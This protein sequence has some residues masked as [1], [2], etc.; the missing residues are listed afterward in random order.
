M[1]FSKPL[2]N[3]L[4]VGHLYR[5]W[6]LNEY[7]G[8]DHYNQSLVFS[9]ATKML[10]PA[11][12][13]HPWTAKHTHAILAYFSGLS[14]TEYRTRHTLLALTKHWRS[15]SDQTPVKETKVPVYSFAN[16][17][18]ESTSASY[19]FKFC[20]YCREQDL[21]AYGMSYW[22]REHHLPGVDICPIHEVAL[23]QVSWR[24]A[25]T[26]PNPATLEGEQLDEALMQANM[27]PILS[28][29]RALVLRA[30]NEATHIQYGNAHKHLLERLVKLGLYKKNP[31][32]HCIYT[33]LKNDLPKYIYT[34]TPSI[35]LDRHFSPDYRELTTPTAQVDKFN[36]HM[37]LNQ[38]EFLG[39]IKP[40]L[41]LLMLAA[42]FDSTE[43]IYKLLFTSNPPNGDHATKLA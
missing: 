7:G 19:P 9:R 34:H 32:H 41:L 29:Y 43:D 33:Y 36:Y 3:E 22:H 39:N 10:R 21:L 12:C 14:E 25:Y 28:R 5:I 26:T 20:Q 23:C 13:A 16:F 24:Q 40:P 17:Y 35:W 38:I 15:I 37:E 27:H 1:L 11:G 2:P 42:I 31:S 6:V 18:S 4:A 30:T 8:S